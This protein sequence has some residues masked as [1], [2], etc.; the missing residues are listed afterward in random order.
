MY[1]CIQSVVTM[2]GSCARACQTS[3]RNI[4]L[5]RVSDLSK[6]RSMSIETSVK[7]KKSKGASSSSS[8]K[9]KLIEDATVDAVQAVAESPN[10]EA[11]GDADEAADPSE[12]RTVNEELEPEPDAVSHAEQRKRRKLEKKRKVA[13]TV[14]D[15][16]SNAEPADQTAMSTCDT[17]KEKRSGH[18]VWVGNLSFK[19]DSEKVCLAV[20]EEF[21]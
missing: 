2:G 7:Q 13:T 20:G 17:N 8:K 5:L 21:K 6:Y 18:G 14:D 11:S 15:A 16:E 12:R 1:R 9:R 3:G 19:T 4:V 10:V